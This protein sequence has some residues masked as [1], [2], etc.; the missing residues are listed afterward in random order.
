[1]LNGLNIFKDVIIRLN[2]NNIDYMVSGSVAMNYY[3]IPRMTIDLD[4]IV[5]IK[6][7]EAF[8]MAFKDDYY[9]DECSVKDAIK[10][11][12]LFNIIHLDELMKVDFIIKK[13]NDYRS[14]EFERRKKIIFNDFFIYIVSIE[15]LVI[16]KM[17]WA[18]KRNSEQQIKDIKNLLGEKIDLI[19]IKKWIKILGIDD[20]YKEID[21][22]S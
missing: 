22:S 9:I 2:R 1:L 16:S 4:I 11:K 21:G 7:P 5:E 10:N 19:Y 17:L 15:D 6:D 18:I 8:F 20:F 12:S 14:K 13:D 3:S